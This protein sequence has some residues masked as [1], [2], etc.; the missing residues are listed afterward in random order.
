MR[1][2]V[3]KNDVDAWARAFLTGLAEIRPD[4]GKTVSRR[5]VLTSRSPPRRPGSSSLRSS[6]SGGR[7]SR[8]RTRAGLPALVVGH[9]PVAHRW[10]PS[11]DQLSA[12]GPTWPQPGW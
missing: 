10:A 5:A 9:Q 7:A 6:H 11:A 2:T 1:R 12:A 8:P 3:L 4:H